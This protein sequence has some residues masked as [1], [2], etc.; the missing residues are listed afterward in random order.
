MV[1]SPHAQGLELTWRN[2]QLV[3]ALAAII[4]SA[5]DATANC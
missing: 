3:A 4:V 2:P 5:A 1:L